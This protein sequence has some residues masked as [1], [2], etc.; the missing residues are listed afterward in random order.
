M[1]TSTADTTIGA[2]KITNIGETMTDKIKHAGS[3]TLGAAQTIAGWLPQKV[4]AATY[5]VL[6]TAILL[7]AVW[8]LVPELL[9]GKILKTFSIL[10]FGMAALNT[11]PKE[12]SN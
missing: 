2:Q 10:G 3:S 1:I 4:R 7:E 5:T 11:V 12:T 9:E 6:G 8:D